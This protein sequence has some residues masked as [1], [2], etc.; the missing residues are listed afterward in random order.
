MSAIISDAKGVVLLVFTVVGVLGTVSF[1]VWASNQYHYMLENPQEGTD[2]IPDI[3]ERSAEEMA[4]DIKLE[5][6][7]G[8]IFAGLS[9]LYGVAK[10]LENLFS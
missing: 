4:E 10:T 8:L 7:L 5:V 3:V 6:I 9:A 1:A 2:I